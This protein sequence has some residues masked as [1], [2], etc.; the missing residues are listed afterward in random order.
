MTFQR[1]L[2]ECDMIIYRVTKVVV[3]P[4][5]GK[6]AWEHRW[7]ATRAQAKEEE[8]ALRIAQFEA[9]TEKMEL[10]NDKHSIVNAL[11]MGTANFTVWEGQRV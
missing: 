1:C 10:A 8:Q 4:E 6:D 5:D 2:V 11:N 7:F 3:P 9:F